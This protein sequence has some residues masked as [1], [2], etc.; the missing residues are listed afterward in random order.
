MVMR[1]LINMAA[2]LLIAASAQTVHAQWT[3][4][5]NDVLNGV[6]GTLSYLG[7]DGGAEQFRLDF[8]IGA[9]ALVVGSRMTAV[10]IK[11]WGGNTY[12]SFTFD[13]FGVGTWT[14]GPGTAGISSGGNSG[15]DS[16]NKPGQGG[17]ACIQATPDQGDLLL[18][19]GESFSFAFN[20]V[21]VSDKVN[22]TGLGAHVGIGF[23]QSDGTGNVGITSELTTHMPEPEIYAMMGLGLGLLGWM[24]RRKRLNDAGANA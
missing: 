10:D 7:P 22:M 19:G 21:G 12:T 6:S 15:A 24:G 5:F 4:S 1:K 2:A 16:C 9:G 13:P 23:T 3:A 11:A 17:F 8:T 18:A 14:D 20:V